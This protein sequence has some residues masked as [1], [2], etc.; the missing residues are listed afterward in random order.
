MVLICLEIVDGSK[1]TEFKASYPIVWLLGILLGSA[2]MRET[3]A[4]EPIV[5]LPFPALPGGYPQMK[6]YAY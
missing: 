3:R 4:N 2:E 5:R 1:H 6:K